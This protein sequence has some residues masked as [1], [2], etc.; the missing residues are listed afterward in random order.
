MRA[1]DQEYAMTMSDALRAQIDALLQQHPVVLFM[2]GTRDAP[3]CGFSANS[4]RILGAIAPEF[5]DVDVLADPE[6]REGI[7]VYGQW[8]TIPQL[9]VRG[10]LVG[11]ADILSEMANNG[12]LHALIGVPAPDRTPPAIHIT[13]KAA[14]AIGQALTDAGNEV[15]HLAID[16]HFRA[17][18]FLKAAGGYEIRAESAGLVLH[19]DLPTAQRARGLEIDWVETMQGAGL[20]IRNP[21]AT[22]EVRSMNVQ[23][24]RTAM[25]AASVHVIDVR[26]GAARAFAPFAGARELETDESALLALAKDTPLAFLCHHGQSSRVAAERFRAAGF[27]QLFNVDGGIDAWSLHIDPRVPRY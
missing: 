14:D 26:P 23:A 15:L 4:V 16:E 18:F 20:S 3:R 25:D 2:K 8:P 5:F 13:A 6:L 10:E 22:P 1:L 27:T 7:K 19:M 9:Y 12:A 24:L 17:Q 21:N 11:G